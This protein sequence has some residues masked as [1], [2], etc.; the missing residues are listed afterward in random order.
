MD[1]EYGTPTENAN[2]PWL[3]GFFDVAAETLAEIRLDWDREKEIIRAQV[4]S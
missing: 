4:A 3:E 2:Q 1:S